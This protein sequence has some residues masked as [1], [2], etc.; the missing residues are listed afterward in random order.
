LPVNQSYRPALQTTSAIDYRIGGGYKPI[1][2]QVD[3]F[4]WYLLLLAAMASLYLPITRDA[5][6][7]FVAT[8][9]Y[10]LHPVCAETVNYIVQRGDL[11]ST[12][13]VVAAL[14]AFIRWPSGRRWGWYLIPFG[15]A[16]LVKPP[17]L[18]FPALLAA[19]VWLFE[20]KTPMLRA[21]APSA[22]LAIVAACWLAHMTP[23]TA[24]TGGRDAANYL[25]TQPFVALRYFAM[26][27]APVGLSADND[28]P[29]V[30]GPG[31]AR[32]FAGFLF[33]AALAAAIAW[34]RIREQWKPVAFGLIWFVVALLPTSL[35]PLAEVATDHRMFFPFVG[36]SLAVTV[37]AADL[38]RRRAAPAR[39]ATVAAVVVAAV[40]LAES[41]AVHARNDVWRTEESLWQDVTIK[42]PGNGRGWMNFGV[43][44]MARG[45]YVNAVRAF[46]Q[47]L[48][49]TPN[50]H[51]LEINLGV[52]L[53]QLRRP[54]DAERHF[55]RA[56]ALEPRDW[57]S[58]LF[59]A[60][61]LSMVGRTSDALA[62]ARL[63][64]ELNPA[65]A[66]A[67]VLA[68]SLQQYDGTPESFL[69]Q[70]LAA[71]QV[72]RYRECIESATRALALRPDYAEAYN[73]IAAA[74]NAL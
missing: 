11:L 13:G 59:M 2:F 34:T 26:F 73:N 61:W 57:R 27:F 41:V 25:W 17:T 37:V 60:R 30:T 38:L 51:L 12:L 68:Q 40:L 65:D 74:Q 63:A 9:I 69:S 5:W 54:G 16:A 55:L 56:I 19:Y 52:S 35:T 1:V 62:H 67:A 6:V 43:A 18:V 31:D 44:L 71:Y 58:H 39:R 28:W 3:T 47:A 32:V 15:L 72:G 48:P 49:L 24:T 66:E 36:L 64:A 8:S 42:S 21:I 23:P 46:E 29:L 20:K 7:A 10:A 53:G 70:S 33:L 14:V 4:L 22:A 45:D 50:Y